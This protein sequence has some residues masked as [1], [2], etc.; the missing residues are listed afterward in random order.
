MD[1]RDMIRAYELAEI[2]GACADEGFEADLTERIVAWHRAG[3]TPSGLT[4]LHGS[5]SATYVLAVA[6][7]LAERR[8]IT[9]ST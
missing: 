8:P 6:R 4:E 1:F 7:K 3:P 5:G 9:P 2:R